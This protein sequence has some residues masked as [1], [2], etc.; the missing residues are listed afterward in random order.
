MNP[1]LLQ[2]SFTPLPASE[3]ASNPPVAPSNT[4]PSTSLS[5][6]DPAGSRSCVT[7]RRRKV[8]CNKRSPCS[9]CVKGGVECVYPPPGRLRRKTKRPQDA[10]L[11]T[12]LKRLEGVIEN[13]S[14]KNSETESSV[15]ST[16]ASPAPRNNDAATNKQPPSNQD[17][18]S[19]RLENLDPN[20]ELQGG[21]GRLVIEEGRSRYVSNRLWASLGDEVGA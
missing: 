15:A 20:K 18:P 16:V 5:P 8:R 10:E 9:N 6:Q 11:M 13:L 21:F 7:C 14:G 2:S 3:P 4:N 12:R 1:S 17:G 19:P